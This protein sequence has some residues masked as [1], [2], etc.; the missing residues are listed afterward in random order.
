VLTHLKYG[1]HRSCASLFQNSNGVV[2]NIN[3]GSFQN[4]VENLVIDPYTQCIQTTCPYHHCGLLHYAR[5]S[6][7]GSYFTVVT[8]T[9]VLLFTLD[10]NKLGYTLS[11][12]SNIVTGARSIDSVPFTALTSSSSTDV[13][14]GS[15]YSKK[16]GLYNFKC[17]PPVCKKTSIALTVDQASYNRPA[18]VY[19]SSAKKGNT[20]GSV[21]FYGISFDG[22]PDSP[23]EDPNSFTRKMCFFGDNGL[24]MACF[25]TFAGQG[26]YLHSE[27]NSEGN[28]PQTLMMIKEG[29]RNK[30][31]ANFEMAPGELPFGTTKRIFYY[32][33][34]ID[35]CD[36]SV[37]AVYYFTSS[38]ELLR[39]CHRNTNVLRTVESLVTDDVVVTSVSFNGNIMVYATKKYSVHV[40]TMNNMQCNQVDYKASSRSTAYSPEDVTVS[41][42]GTGKFTVV[43]KIGN[44]FYGCVFR[45]EET[46]SSLIPVVRNV[47]Q[48]TNTGI[49]LDDT[50]QNNAY[51]GCIT[52]TKI[53]D[54]DDDYLNMVI[55]HDGNY[56]AT[57]TK[58]GYMYY[59]ARGDNNNNNDYVPVHSQ[60]VD[61]L[62][63]ASID[64]LGKFGEKVVGVLYEREVGVSTFS[65]ADFQTTG[66][67]VYEITSSPYILA[68]SI[69]TTGPSGEKYICRNGRSITRTL[70]YGRYVNISVNEQYVSL[71]GQTRSNFLHE[72][73]PAVIYNF[74]NQDSPLV[75]LPSGVGQGL[76]F[77][78]DENNNIG[79]YYTNSASDKIVTFTNTADADSYSIGPGNGQ[80]LYISPAHGCVYYLEASDSDDAN[81]KRFCFDNYGPTKIDTTFVSWHSYSLLIRGKY[82]AIKEENSFKLCTT[83]ITCLP[84][85]DLRVYT[86]N[87]S[88]T[89]PGTPLSAAKPL[90]DFSVSENGFLVTAVNYEDFGIQIKAHVCIGHYGDNMVK[91]S[92]PKFSIE[93]TVYTLEVNDRCVRLPDLDTV[94]VSISPQGNVIFVLGTADQ[95]S[96]IHRLLFQRGDNNVFNFQTVEWELL[97]GASGVKDISF[98][99]EADN[100]FFALASSLQ[101]TKVDCRKTS[102][103]K[104]DIYLMVLFILYFQVHFN[105]VTTT[106]LF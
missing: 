93:S 99:E 3:F 101:V 37:G 30:T 34:P 87:P 17:V 85:V 66:N 33:G 76:Y 27:T 59:K 11:N 69:Y 62:Y 40:C 43:T 67:G 24:P 45:K 55:S 48:L 88:T 25:D 57:S 61:L 63:P 29:D 51:S 22:D 31:T 47:F 28:D 49:N 36:N 35:G 23:F 64:L 8:N 103:G 95:G 1:S 44:A 16:F 13:V 12:P 78:L 80:I 71:H 104:V 2:L 92:E 38:G 81:I 15:F 97:D 32:K 9:Q 4:A 14:T 50:I 83:K 18:Q 86:T 26:L 54:D 10:E 42:S 90:H 52:Y 75:E 73:S 98:F 74:Q 19:I 56:L 21:V 7:D 39:S 77:G 65:C 89:H 46:G 60:D 68:S 102:Q 94:K 106:T 20:E 72:G 79:G 96:T 82:V 84:S 100:V 53:E 105:T 70:D 5:L 58:R 41:A 91:L 6:P